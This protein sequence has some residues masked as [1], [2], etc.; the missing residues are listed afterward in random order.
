VRGGSWGSDPLQVR[1][2]FR[3]AAPAETRSARV[4]FRIARDL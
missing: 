3:I 4:G 2:A 1:S